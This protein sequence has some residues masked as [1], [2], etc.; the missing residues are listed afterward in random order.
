M[1]QRLT[2]P[3]LLSAKYRIAAADRRDYPPSYL[4]VYE[5]ELRRE[6]M[7]KLFASAEALVQENTTVDVYNHGDRVVELSLVV[8][9]TIEMCVMY[10][11]C[12]VKFIPTPVKMQRGLPPRSWTRFL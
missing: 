12:P 4:P 10:P 8:G 11:V 9:N 5:A 2:Q 3:L 1:A 6:T 7:R